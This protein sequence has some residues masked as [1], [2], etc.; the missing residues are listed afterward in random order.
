MVLLHTVC[1][2]QMSPVN[3]ILPASLVFPSQ[4][5]CFIE[6]S[7]LLEFRVSFGSDKDIL[8]VIIV[9]VAQFYE[10]CK[11]HC[12]EHFKQVNCMVC[13]LYLKK[14]ITKRKKKQGVLSPL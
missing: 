2:I 7:T 10:Y 5:Q 8:Y 14:T 11:N 13:K 12:T 4:Q 1:L 9:L 3:H 6:G